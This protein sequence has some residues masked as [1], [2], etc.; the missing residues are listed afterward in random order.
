LACSHMPDVD[1]VIMMTQDAVINT[2][3][4]IDRLSQALDD[5]RVGVA[6]G[7]QLGRETGNA[8]ERHGRW[9]NY[10]AVSRIQTIEDR[11]TLGIRTAFSSNS[12]SIY[13][14]EALNEVG[15][16]PDRVI[17]GEDIYVAAKMLLAG[18]DIA[19]VADAVVVHSH[20]FTVRQEFKRYF[21]I[22]VHHA[23]ERWLLDTFGSARG[24]GA[25]F[26][27]SELWYLLRHAPHLIP[28]AV[29]RTVSKL[30]AYRL[31]KKWEILPRGLVRRLSSS[32]LFWKS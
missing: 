19:Y 31:G 7:R 9:F 16:F 17:S 10:P 11:D 15:G 27:R 23:R 21:D 1:A 32:N 24:E 6:Y 2:P 25:R 4:A 20:G 28:L 13:R 29:I 26:V 5:P 30:A 14:Q 8:I 3:D 12:F 18:W 22:G